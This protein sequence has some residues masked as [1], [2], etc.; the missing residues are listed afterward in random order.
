MSDASLTNIQMVR[1][2][3]PKV[4]LAV[5]GLGV[6]GAGAWWLTRPAGPVGEPEDPRKLLVVGGEDGVAST[7]GELGFVAEQGSFEELAAAGTKDGA[8][9]EGIEAILHYADVRG[10][11]YVAVADPIGHGVSGI[12]ITG[13]SADVTEQ[14]QWAVFSVGD[15][16]MPPK[17][18]VQP[19]D[20][21]LEL[22][23]YVQVLRA[24]FVQDRLANTLFA[25]N[26]LPMDA[27]ELQPK[28]T[29]AIEL[30]GAY[31]NL[32]RRVTKDLRA[33]EEAV[34]EGETIEPKP[35]VLAK[36][37][38]MTESLALADGTVLSLVQSWHLDDPW[39][40]EVSLEADTELELWFQPAASSEPSDRE[41]CSSL[42]GGVLP[43]S[44]DQRALSPRAD[45]MLIESSSGG[46]EVWTLDVAA[47][48]CQWQRK[49]KLPSPRADELSWGVPDGSG[50]VLRG[51]IH[52]D[53]P[54]I[55]LWEPGRE[56]PQV[57]AAPGCSETSA[58]VWLDAEHLAFACHWQP[59]VLDE[60]DS[61]YDDY[62]GYDDYED[63]VDE[64]VE[65]EDVDP[66]AVEDEPAPPPPPPEQVWI[67]VVRLGDQKTVAVPGTALGEHVGGYSLR[68]VP[69]AKGLDLL[70][71]HPWN[72]ELV[73]VRSTGD[74]G[75]L[76]AGAEAT[77]SALAEADAAAA[78]A[79][80]S[81]TPGMDPAV[82][83]AAAPGADPGADPS[84]SP[85]V[86]APEPEAPLLRPA[87]VPVGSMV[88]ALA[89]DGLTIATLTVTGDHDTLSLS[90]DG[91]QLVFV[92][93]DGRSVMVM[94]LEGG[95]PTTLSD[96]DSRQE[97]PLFTADGEA[98]VFTSRFHGNDRSERVGRLA[99]LP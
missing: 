99:R 85:V 83:P 64:D 29:A 67:Y 22:P 82:D 96:S 30:F 88:A 59:P 97:L 72:D 84:A 54:A 5:L 19:K 71:V 66:A 69:G 27:V 12:T 11:G 13:D 38:E 1:P 77:F 52:E 78:I 3:G 51:A 73:R 18:T 55:H 49:G 65:V 42:R 58:P 39:D 45:A 56:Q 4:F 2:K 61:P 15:L 47:A 79:V 35:V 26:Q 41:R 25:E 70:A 62:G 23:G 7:L 75:S 60:L 37:L 16:G 98:V 50:R 34:V 8:S 57:I 81:A 93:D 44:G 63:E 32:D 90:A 74:L 14:D 6:I 20:S 87:F 94:P 68:A 10:F 24:A 17:V 21:E 40:P 92:S 53:G 86:A 9:G 36:A 95:S 31:Q 43:L 28:I 80:P 33:R 91:T 48:A 89:E 46:L 76:L